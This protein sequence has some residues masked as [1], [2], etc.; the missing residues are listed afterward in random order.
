VHDLYIV[1]PIMMRLEIIV[2]DVEM[3]IG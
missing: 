2:S 1:Q 3:L